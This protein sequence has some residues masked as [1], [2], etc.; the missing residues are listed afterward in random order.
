MN[1]II[2]TTKY[3]FLENLL[4]KVFWLHVHVH[5]HVYA[6]T[7]ALNWKQYVHA[8]CVIKCVTLQRP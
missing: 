3:S 1:I 7:N 2:F 5:V 6:L 4:L 8:K